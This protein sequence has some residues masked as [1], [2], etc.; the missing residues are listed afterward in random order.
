MITQV[1]P[2]VDTGVTATPGGRPFRGINRHRAGGMARSIRSADSHGW[3]PVLM[4]FSL[5]SLAKVPE[6]LL[7]PSRSR[8]AIPGVCPRLAAVPLGVAVL[9]ASRSAPESDDGPLW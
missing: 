9:V 1:D 4:C 3:P 6:V 2:T 8:T 5:N 7:E